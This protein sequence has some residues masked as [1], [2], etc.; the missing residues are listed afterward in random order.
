[1]I[2]EHIVYATGSFIV[3][4]LAIIIGVYVAS[5]AVDRL[6]VELNEWDEV[7]KGNIAVA[8]YFVG[9]LLSVGVI[10]TPSIAGLYNMLPKI[11]SGALPYQAII[12]PVNSVI[13]SI[14]IAVIVQYIGIRT[15]T[16][17]TRGINEWGELKRGNVAVGLM[18]AGTLVVVGLIVAQIVEGFIRV[19][20]L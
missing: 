9:V 6:T 10:I 11:A 14:I 17:I 8:V 13:L 5:K 3:A 7:R 19:L 1:M 16:R 18:M 12:P 20:I 2:F 4:L 15:F